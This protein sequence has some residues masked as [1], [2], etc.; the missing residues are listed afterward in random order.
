MP[1][2]QRNERDDEHRKDL[3][4]RHV[5]LVELDRRQVQ[6]TAP[7]RLVASCIL[8]RGE[9]VLPSE[10]DIYRLRVSVRPNGS[11]CRRLAAL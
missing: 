3:V 6:K 4:R 7:I 5:A 2:D 11:S 1:S 10:E 8:E 9:S